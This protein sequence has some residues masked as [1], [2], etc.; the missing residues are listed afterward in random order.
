MST[1]TKFNI[2]RENFPE[3]FYHV[4]N[5][6]ISQDTHEFTH[7]LDITDTVMEY[8][9]SRKKMGE[10]TA[11]VIFYNIKLNINLIRNHNL[12]TDQSYF[13]IKRNKIAGTAELNIIEETNGVFKPVDG[14]QTELFNSLSLLSIFDKTYSVRPTNLITPWL[15]SD[16]PYMFPL[17]IFVPHSAASFDE[18]TFHVLATNDTTKVIDTEDNIVPLINNDIWN[19]ITDTTKHTVVDSVTSYKTFF[20]PITS[21]TTVT[22]PSVGDAIPVTVTCADTSVS[23]LY[24]DQVVG[25]LDKLQVDLT[26]GVGTFT[27][28]TNTLSAGETVKVKIG[29]K[30]Y[31][32]VNIFTKTLA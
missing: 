9:F 2:S 16:K 30:K 5:D 18:C 29:H 20:A 28:L 10:E 25:V 21:T 12:L 3:Y 8:K 22:S 14:A 7:T 13:T 24:L 17:R 6:G 4:E 27:I 15:E 23:K 31:S 19:I 1:I 11:D 32:S 26:N